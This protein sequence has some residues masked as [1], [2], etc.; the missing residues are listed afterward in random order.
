MIT[1]LNSNEEAKEEILE[2][3]DVSLQY[4]RVKSAEVMGIA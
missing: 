2:N 3:K 4:F 1:I